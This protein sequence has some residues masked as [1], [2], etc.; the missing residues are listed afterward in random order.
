MVYLGADGSEVNV[1]VSGGGYVLLLVQ[2]FTGDGS[3]RR[4]SLS[5]MSRSSTKTHE[6]TENVTREYFL[7]NF[8][9][10]IRAHK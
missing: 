3:M 6:Y 9:K 8:K 7:D 5:S 2:Y 10:T 1:D 4:H